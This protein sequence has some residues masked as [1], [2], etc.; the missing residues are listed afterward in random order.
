MSFTSGYDHLYRAGFRSPIPPSVFSVI[1]VVKKS[2]TEITENTEMKTLTENVITALR[3]LCPFFYFIPL[4]CPYLSFTFKL[5]PD[6]I[7]TLITYFEYKF[8]VISFYSN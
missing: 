4:I 2:T 6:K 7:I 5:L 1:S 8:I 3:P